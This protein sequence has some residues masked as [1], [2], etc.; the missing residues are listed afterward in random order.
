MVRKTHKHVYLIHLDV[1]Y[2]RTVA[3]CTEERKSKALESDLIFII[4]V[5]VIITILEICTCYIKDI[6]EPG[7]IKADVP[8]TLCQP[9]T[10]LGH[11]SIDCIL[12]FP[13]AVVWR[14]MPRNSPTTHH[15]VSWQQVLRGQGPQFMACIS[16]PRTG[17]Y[18]LLQLLGWL[19][20]GNWIQATAPT[21]LT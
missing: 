14:A 20:F 7:G 6:K 13:M 1:H 12:R 8:T 15:H 5:C 2:S 11:F 17:T 18:H 16:A 19:W 3:R 21:S 10:H 9:G 4:S